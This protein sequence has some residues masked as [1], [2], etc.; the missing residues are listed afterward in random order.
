MWTRLFVGLYFDHSRRPP[1]RL[2]QSR[3]VQVDQYGR[4]IRN[5]GGAGSAASAAASAQRIA[6]AALTKRMAG[7]DFGVE[8]AVRVSAALGDTDF[9]N[10]V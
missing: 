5:G 4:P 2:I 3:R 7:R 1:P 10:Q 6:L 9:F 8:E